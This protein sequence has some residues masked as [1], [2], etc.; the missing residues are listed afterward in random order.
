MKDFRNIGGYDCGLYYNTKEINKMTIEN[1]E[2]VIECLQQTVRG[3]ILQ[4]LN[5]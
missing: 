3:K 2:I 1:M 4:E 5:K